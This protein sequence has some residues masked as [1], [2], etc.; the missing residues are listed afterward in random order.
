MTIESSQFIN[1]LNTAFPRSTD[2]LKEGDDHIRLIKANL[3]NTFPNI[4]T[5]ISISSDTLNYLNNNIKVSPTG[6]VFNNTISTTGGAGVDFRSTEVQVGNASGDVS[7]MNGLAA[8]NLNTL[9]VIF[10]AMYPV[11]FVFCTGESNTNPGTLPLFKGTS[12][13]PYGAGRYMVSAGNGGDNGPWG[14]GIGS[15]GSANFAIGYGNMPDHS[16]D[17]T[18][19]GSGTTGNSNQDINHQHIHGTRPPDNGGGV[20]IY[21]DSGVVTY[22]YSWAR[23]DHQHS[24]NHHVTSTPWNKDLNAHNHNFGVTVYG[25]TGGVKQGSGQT[26]ITYTPA[27]TSAYYWKRTS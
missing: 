16:H 10:K 4:T 3:K 12:W 26:P 8:L 13:T 25:T 17:V 23:S 22:G 6:V 11:G 1:Q 24:G 21:G 20:G 9:S 7:Q 18:S 27:F 2:L 5:S 14:I 19:S 15:A